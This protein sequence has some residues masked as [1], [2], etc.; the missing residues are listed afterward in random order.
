MEEDSSKDKNLHTKKE[1][2]YRGVRQRPWGKFAAEI[3]DPTKHG[4][5]VWLGTFLTA[6]EAARAYDRA[7]FEMRGASAVLNFP[8]EYPSCSSMSSSSSL[9]P[10]S[11]SSMLKHDHGKQVIEFEC[12]D[13]KLLEDLLDFDDYAYEKDLPKK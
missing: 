1:P 7:A 8:N 11:S 5:R 2:H 10:S 4:G 12:L 9:T 3:R 13:D 6:E